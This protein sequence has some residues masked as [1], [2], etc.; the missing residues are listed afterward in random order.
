METRPAKHKLISWITGDSR[1]GST[2]MLT[3]QTSPLSKMESKTGRRYVTPRLVLAVL[4]PSLRSPAPCQLREPG[5]L[6]GR[7]GTLLSTPKQATNSSLPQGLDPAV[8]WGHRRNPDPTA[9]VGERQ[10]TRARVQ[11]LRQKRTLLA[12]KGKGRHR[13]K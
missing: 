1:Q 8:F 5:N 13:Q 6:A 11:S 12:G 9:D 3:V 10:R 7:N 4:W 2:K